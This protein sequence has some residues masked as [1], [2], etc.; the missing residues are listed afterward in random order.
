MWC[1]TYPV[2][3]Q[4]IK[5]YFVIYA[6]KGFVKSK[7]AQLAHNLLSRYSIIL[8]TINAIASFVDLFFPK[9]N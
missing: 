9:P 1:T 4:L 5:K 7:N 6:V 2:L 8:S 3:I